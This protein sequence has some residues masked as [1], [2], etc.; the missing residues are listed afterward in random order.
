MS[1]ARTRRPATRATLRQWG[2]LTLVLALLCGALGSLGGLGR[3]DQTLYDAAVG[4][5][6]HAP[7]SEVVLIAIDDASLAQVGRWPWPRAVHAALIER[8]A[9]A[10]P[11][12]IGLDLILTE[13]EQ[14]GGQSPGDAALA[15]AIA[16]A[17][18]VVLPVLAQARGEEGQRGLATAT[19]VPELAKVAAALGHIHLEVD[20]DGIARSAFLREGPPYAATSTTA[21]ASAGPTPRWP[22]FALA[23]RNL[24]G[25]PPATLP[26]ERGHASAGSWGRDYWLHIPYAGPPGTFTQ[27]SYVDVLKG[28]VPPEQLA[29]KYLLVGATAA[30]MG[31]AFPTPVSGR[32]RPMPGIEIS[33]NILDALL[34]G[35]AIVRA[36][37]VAGA[38]LSALPVLLLMACL[39]RL[40]PRRGLIAAGLA[41][42][43]TLFACYLLL[44]AGY[45]VAPAA[46]L[47]GLLLAYPLWSWRRLEATMEAL[48]AEIMRLQAEPRVL[49]DSATAG[50]PAATGADVLE[51]NLLALESAG[52]RLRAARRFVSDTLDSLPE[53]T[54]VAGRDGQVLLANRAS[55]QLWQSGTPD[56][57]RGL[58]LEKLLAP[59]ALK[60][61]GAQHL[62]WDALRQLAEAPAGESG[63]RP[64]VEL[65]PHEGRDL[66]ARCAPCADAAGRHAG[67]IVSL[68]DITPL[69]EAERSRDEVLSFLSHDMRSPQSSILAL[70]ELHELDPD[71]NPKE[72]VH[73]RIAQYAHRTLELS[74]QFLQMARAETKEYEL[75]PVDLGMIAEEAIEEAWTAAGQKSIALKLEFDGEPVPVLADA[76]LLRRAI[77]NLL[78]NA[79]KYS[80]ENTATT[81][82]VA[83]ENGWAQCKVAD[84]GYGMSED[85]LQN[86]FKRFRRFSR[87]GQPK[88]QGAGLGMAFVK[89]VAEKHGGRLL[90]QSQVGAGTTFTLQLPPSAQ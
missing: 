18:N 25:N 41:V 30:G 4:L 84:Q 68:S 81:I 79:V 21:A 16:S 72:A 56:A 90:V 58:A 40:T 53:A 14:A 26:G 7:S 32:S 39:L 28:S 77:L 33:A 22:H 59:F 17:G 48:G 13:P 35:R 43:L 45:W 78:T 66:L 29:G 34:T 2:T 70:L 10:K 23:L 19:P 61:D 88:A 9:A 82:T 47:T 49:P 63:A 69:R 80:P 73:E 20:Q 11:R 75:A 74:E 67:W 24:G 3:P 37:P 83:L 89:T 44:R 51:T 6:S 87:P 50:S 71:D 5:T 64:A 42:L 54:L 15:K 31:D 76:A 52:E 8:L 38:L 55:A 1:L 36:G 60:A 85:N 57:L 12:A 62:S 65:A 46:A 86:L 27:H